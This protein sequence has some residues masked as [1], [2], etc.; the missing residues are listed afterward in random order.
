MIGIEHPVNDADLVSFHRPELIRILSELELTHDCWTL[1]NSGG[2]GQAKQKYLAQ[3]PAEPKKAYESRLDRSTYTPIFRDAIQS[4]A[5][6]LS[7]FQLMDAP[8]SLLTAEKNVDLQ[9]SSIQT[10]M[11][12]C[13]EL[14][15]R[16]GGAFVMVDIMPATGANNFFDQMNDG[17]LPYL[18][19]IQR[20]DV[21]NWSV[22]YERGREVIQHATVRQLRS[23]PD[24]TGFGTTV[25]PVYYVL[26]PGVVQMYRLVKESGGGG[27]R[28]I[29]VLVDEVQTS[30]PIVPIVWYGATTN[31]FAQ[32][33]IPLS[34]L[35]ELSIQHFQMR[36]D[37]IELLHK[38]AM[39]VPV[40]KGATL[41]ADGKPAPLVIGPN[42]AVDLSGEPGSGFE[43]A[44][45]SG[46]SLERHQAEITHL[47]TLMDRCSLNFLYGAN[48]KTATEASLR[49]SQVASSVSS[50]VR[51]K[52]SAFD[53]IMKLWA[54]Y[55]GETASITAESGIAINDSLIN[56]PLGAS[57]MAQLVN[58]YKE[59]LLSRQTVLDE[60]QRGGV[61]DPDMKIDDEISRI[62]EDHMDSVEQSIEDSQLIQDSQ[63]EDQQPQDSPSG[64]SETQKTQLAAQNA[65]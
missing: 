46:K 15:L 36:S 18:I 53:L 9:G 64:P 65:Q 5:G 56:K 33:D 21:I 26:R 43:F 50:L 8:P 54:F 7:R 23:V 17:R 59:N 27:Q 2:R 55:A 32:G 25:E 11:N 29:N 10:F 22:T 51:N 4:Y 3:E 31:R 39:P 13:D 41:G 19:S 62:E 28:W 45:P 58:L 57:E 6:L 60:L 34:G 20:S 61:L 37:L 14:A 44:E 16:D 30:L 63:P 40:R 12:I 47:E 48:I 35:A 42:T 1:L 52:T 38:C 24:S 49:A